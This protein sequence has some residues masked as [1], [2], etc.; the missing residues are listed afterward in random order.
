MASDMFEEHH[1][2]RSSIILVC[3]SHCLPSNTLTYFRSK[4]QPY[5]VRCVPSY[6]LI[7]ARLLRT[8]YFTDTV[9]THLLTAACGGTI[10]VTLCA[11]VDVIKSR[12]Q[13]STVSGEVGRTSQIEDVFPADK[14]YDTGS[15]RCPRP[16][17]QEGWPKSPVPR[18]ASGLAQNDSHYN[19]DFHVSRAIKEDFMNGC[20]TPVSH[21]IAFVKLHVRLCTIRDSEI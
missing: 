13:S 2:E 8:G 3:R 14:S 10:A 11:P 21:L 17:S 15:I 7:K 18:M 5:F 6:D 9:P 1:Y 20:I 19:T 16:I 12:I 4:G